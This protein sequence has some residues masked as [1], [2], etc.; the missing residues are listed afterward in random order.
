M[1]IWEKRR[2]TYT[3]IPLYLYTPIPSVKLINL[4]NKF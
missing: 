1:E 3:F 4:H 2:N